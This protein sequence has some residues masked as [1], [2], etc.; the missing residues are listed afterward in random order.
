MRACRDFRGLAWLAV[1]FGAAATPAGIVFAGNS[2]GQLAQPVEGINIQ[3]CVDIIGQPGKPALGRCPAYLVDA[4]KAAA[5][6]CAE[7]GGRPYGIAPASVW[8]LDVNGD[9]RLEYAYEIGANV[10]CENAASIFSCG[11]QGC[12]LALVEE[13]KGAWAGIGAIY[14]GAPDEIQVLVNAAPPG[15]YDLKVGCV[16]GDSCTQYAF[17]QWNGQVYDATYLEVGD[18]HVDLAGSLHGL[19]GLVGETAVLATPAPDGAVIARYGSSTEVAIVGQA[20]DY[21]YVSPCNACES[22]FVRKTAVR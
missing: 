4:V 17:Y 20:G 10:A 1:V 11:S 9:G 6:T 14:A 2:V 5:Q 18:V 19:H 7:V 3:R 13:R 8:S 22:G 16:N 15:H 12:P 21:Y